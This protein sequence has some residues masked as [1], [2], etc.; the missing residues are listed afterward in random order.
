MAKLKILLID[1]EADFLDIMGERISRWGYDVATASSGK[2]GLDAI[3]A[4]RPDMVILDY[5]MPEMDGL[6]TLG[7]IRKI[8]KELTVI[9]FTAY[10]EVGAIKGSE[11][12]GVSAFIPKLST[13]SEVPTTLR[14]TLKMLEKQL[15]KK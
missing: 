8:D 10:P 2:E 5:K 6:T 11:K 15:S 7:E 4:D 3:A 9:M 14:T 12:L 1:D 13:Y